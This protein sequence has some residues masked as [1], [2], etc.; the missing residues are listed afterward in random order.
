M[1]VPLLIAFMLAIAFLA[2]N[3]QEIMHRA[4]PALESVSSRTRFAWALRPY[5]A[6]GVGVV[7]ALVLGSLGRVS[8]F[9][10]FQF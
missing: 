1:R 10:Y 2:P 3:T 6:F 5:W 8:E 4:E 9:L 7:L